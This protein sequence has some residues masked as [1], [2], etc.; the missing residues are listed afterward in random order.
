MQLSDQAIQ[1]FIRRYREAYGE[2]LPL[3]E[4]RDMASRLVALYEVL[5]RPLPAEPG[6]LPLRLT[7][8]DDS[9]TW[10]A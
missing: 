8:K 1:E 7:A 2:E 10:S 9:V 4:A 6:A 3:A 5:S